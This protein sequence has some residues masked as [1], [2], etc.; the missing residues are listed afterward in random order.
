LTVEVFK[1]G[2]SLS[3]PESFG[4]CAEEGVVYVK[5]YIGLRFAVAHVHRD[6]VQKIGDRVEAQKPNWI[7]FDFGEKEVVPLP[8]TAG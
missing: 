2:N 3:L 4:E 1:L 7:Y 8:E 6:N 5:I